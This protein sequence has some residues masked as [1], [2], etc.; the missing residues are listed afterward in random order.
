MCLWQE[1]DL[2]IGASFTRFQTM[3]LRDAFVIDSA[4]DDRN[5]VLSYGPCQVLNWFPNTNDHC[6]TVKVFNFYAFIICLTPPFQYSSLHLALL[7][8]DIGRYSHTSQRNFGPLTVHTDQM[9]AFLHSVGCKCEDCCSSLD[10]EII[11]NLMIVYLLQAW[12]FFWLCL[13]CHNLWDVCWGAYCKCELCWIF[14]YI[15]NFIWHLALLAST[16]SIHY[17]S[18][19]SDSRR[20]WSI[21]HIRWIQLSWKSVPQDTFVWVLNTQWRWELLQYIP[22][23]RIV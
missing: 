16:F 4:T 23:I 22:C 19:R 11:Y 15:A 3:L 9:K 6:L 12:P 17:R 18:Q 8:N 2:R 10:S 13:C 5:L 14:V 20:S 7:W 21:L 1:I